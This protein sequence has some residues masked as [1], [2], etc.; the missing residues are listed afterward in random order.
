MSGIAMY[1]TTYIKSSYV[2]LP[3][4]LGVS[5]FLVVLSVTGVGVVVGNAKI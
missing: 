2:Y 5:G 4:E 3:E 1:K